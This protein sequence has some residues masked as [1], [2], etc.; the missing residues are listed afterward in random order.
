[1]R[2]RVRLFV[3]FGAMIV[4]FS[5]VAVDCLPVRTFGWTLVLLGAAGCLLLIVGGIV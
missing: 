2:P 5:L 1:M 4:G 3:C